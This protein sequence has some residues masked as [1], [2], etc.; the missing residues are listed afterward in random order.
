MSYEELLR[1][2][3]T[4]LVDTNRILN[5]M[6]SMKCG[7]VCGKRLIDAYKPT[8][9]ELDKALD[10]YNFY[11][12]ERDMLLEKGRIVGDMLGNIL[13]KLNVDRYVHHVVREI[14]PII[15]NELGNDSDDGLTETQRASLQKFYEN[16]GDGKSDSDLMVLGMFKVLRELEKMPLEV[17]R[18]LAIEI[19]MLGVN[20][21][22]PDKKYNLKSLPNRHDIYG[23]E[24][25]AYYYISWMKVFPDKI[26]LIGLPYKKAYE[27]AVA[28]L[29]T[30]SG[31]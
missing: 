8:S 6:F 29:K 7:E 10:L 31:E 2:Y 20:G 23:Q 28:K 27:S 21:L 12:A 1:T 14:A 19:A 18:G 4:F 24:V 3:P 16:H 22:A 15:P 26:D 11:R 25:L 13:R 5:L 17:V 9:E 30:A